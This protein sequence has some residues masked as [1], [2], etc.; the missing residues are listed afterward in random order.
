MHRAQVPHPPPIRDDASARRLLDL[1]V[2]PPFADET[3]CVPLDAAGRG[4]V[5]TVVSDTGHPE[6]LPR[7]VEVVALAVAGSPLDHLLVASVRPCGG[8]RPDDAA[9]WAD[10]DAIAARH[11]V[12]LVEWYVVGPHGTTCPRVLL[13]QPPRW[14]QP[15]SGDG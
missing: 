11:G 9:R 2:R 8:L 4:S 10:I 3:V 14:P 6:A 5:I 7:V 13:G 1:A 12:R 15:S